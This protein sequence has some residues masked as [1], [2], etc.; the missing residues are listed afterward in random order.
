MTFAQLSE[1]STEKMQET[2]VAIGSCC[3]LH[4]PEIWVKQV[5]MA[6]AGQWD[7]LKAWQD[8]MSGGKE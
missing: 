7:E 6:A 3:S 5:A 8:E 1:T 4:N 2:L